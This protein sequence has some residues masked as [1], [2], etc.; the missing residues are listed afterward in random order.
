MTGTS[1]LLEWRLPKS[2]LKFSKG[3][4]QLS[5]GFAALKSVIQLVGDL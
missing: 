3:E 5:F 2:I 4:G 1:E